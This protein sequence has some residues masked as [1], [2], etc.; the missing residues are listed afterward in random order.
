MQENI[1]FTPSE[2]VYGHEVTATLEAVLPVDNSVKTDENIKHLMQRAEQA[3][4]LA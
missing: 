2:L 4:Q 1:C 3:R